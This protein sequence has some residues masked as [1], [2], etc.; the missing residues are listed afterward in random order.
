MPLLP[1]L[2]Q[3]RGCF[4]VHME[5]QPVVKAKRGSTDAARTRVGCVAVATVARVVGAGV[6]TVTATACVHRSTVIASTQRRLT[7]S[8]TG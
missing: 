4:G 7:Y 1:Q 6:V 2:H 8:R 3:Q 5:R